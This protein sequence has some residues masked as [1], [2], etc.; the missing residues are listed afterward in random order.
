MSAIE[1]RDQYA[2]QILAGFAANPVEKAIIARSE[3]HI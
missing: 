2:A 1:E 3:E